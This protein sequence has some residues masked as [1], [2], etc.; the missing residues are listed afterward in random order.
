MHAGAPYCVAFALLVPGA[1]VAV[2]ED[3]GGAMGRDALALWVHVGAGC[4]L[5]LSP[6]AALTETTVEEEDPT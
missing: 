6:T 4:P 5:C 3:C 1:R 2:C